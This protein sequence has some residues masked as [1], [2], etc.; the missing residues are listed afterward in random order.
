MGAC[1]NRAPKISPYEQEPSLN[2]HR[3]EFEKLGL[4][5]DAIYSLFHT[6]QQIDRDHSSVVRLSIAL[7]ASTLICMLRTIKYTHGRAIPRVRVE[8]HSFHSP[9]PLTP[10]PDCFFTP[11]R[12]PPSSSLAG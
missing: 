6:F 8:S 1:F 10:P 9:P 11:S 7:L 4:N 2:V 5:A 3:D 12:P